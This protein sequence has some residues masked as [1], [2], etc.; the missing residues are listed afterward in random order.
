MT[1]T[2]EELLAEDDPAWP[3]VQTWVKEAR[4]PVEVLPTDEVGR[5]QALVETQVTVRSPMGA[6]I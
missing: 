1:R 4:V 5:G 6:V 2:L 3:L